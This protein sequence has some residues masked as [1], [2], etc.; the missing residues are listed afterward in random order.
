M[1]N[2]RLSFSAF[3]EKAGKVEQNQ[4]LEK[5]Q[6]GRMESCHLCPIGPLGMKN[7]RPDVSKF[8]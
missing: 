4:V 6:G 7:V 1:K 8:S 2:E 5:I 3:K